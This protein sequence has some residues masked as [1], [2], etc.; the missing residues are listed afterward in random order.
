M[1]KPH[2]LIVEDDFRQRTALVTQL[3][4]A[5]YRIS[6]VGSAE[7][8]ND[9]MLT[10]PPDLVLLDRRLP[11]RGGLSVLQEWRARGVTIPVIVVTARGGV[12]DRV[13]GLEAG[14]SD[15]LCKPFAIKE[16]LA[17][18]SVQ[19][20]DYHDLHQTLE[21]TA[22]V[23]HL[24]QR[25]VQRGSETIKLSTREGDLLAYLVKHQGQL[26]MRSELLQVVWAYNPSIVLRT[27]DNTVL[28]L[29]SKLEADP[30]SPRHIRTVHGLG[31]RFD[32]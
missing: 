4:N 1:S 26:V 31:Y 13:C 5:G 16:L 8:A 24:R 11:G 28:R 18:V 32:P 29:R 10:S 19:L 23:V 9:L 14:A 30:S 20:R 27:V 7:E 25:R 21:L 17:R 22:S 12:E 6:A 3:R 2:L 15:Y